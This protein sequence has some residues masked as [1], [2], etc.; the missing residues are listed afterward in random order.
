M[1]SS[2]SNNVTRANI[3]LSALR[4]TYAVIVQ[5]KK[6][7]YGLIKVVHACSNNDEEV[8]LFPIQVQAALVPQSTI[9]QYTLPVQMFFLLEKYSE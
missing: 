8:C 3:A 1:V 9:P 2:T 5:N 7:K 4:D 6:E